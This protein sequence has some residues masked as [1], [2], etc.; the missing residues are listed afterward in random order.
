MIPIFVTGI[1]T[2]VG[3]TLVSAILT[4]AL[5]ADYWKPVQAGIAEGTDAQ[6][7]QQL[8]T[9]SSTVIHPSVYNLKMAASPHIA[10]R[11][12]N[13]E[14]Q[15]EKILEA[16]NVFARD[17][18]YLIIEGA[19]G[20][21]VPIADHYFVADLIRD[22]HAKVIIVSRNY[23]GSINHSLLTARALQAMGLDTVGWVF[24]DQY[25]EYEHEI[26][27]WSGIPSIG[28]IPHSHDTGKIFVQ[29]QAGRIVSNLKKLV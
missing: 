9:N 19:G 6:T 14:I 2:G 20:L 27:A 11:D 18:R 13:L 7:V 26:V 29:E 1:G 28:S 8:I 24:N 16:Y 10:A 12:E 21:L 3:K 5:Q 23:L 4:E 17:N 25:L 22:I 15:P